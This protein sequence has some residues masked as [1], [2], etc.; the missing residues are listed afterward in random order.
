VPVASATPVEDGLMDD[1]PSPGSLLLSRLRNVRD[2]TAWTEFVAIYAPVIY[3]IAR[4]YR[5]QDADAGDV[6]Q[7]VLRAA[8]RA[9]PGFTLE[10]R[11]GSFDGWLFT[12]ARNAVRKHLLARRRQPAGRG[13]TGPELFAHQPAPAD[14]VA[15]RAN[16]EFA[17]RQFDWAAV[18]ARRR[19][20]ASTW[21]AF[22]QT[23][24]E[25]KDARAVA[26]TLGMSPGAVYIARS[27]VLACL[28]SLI[29]PADD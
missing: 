27:R 1:V 15:T 2:E 3:R 12:V 18:Q 7:E 11:R 26:R 25:G 10:L 6:T 17:R 24:V 23:A 29:A 20:R 5:L 16:Q 19:F 22:W 14:F 8:V 9:L 4:R 28:R 13:G 21:Q